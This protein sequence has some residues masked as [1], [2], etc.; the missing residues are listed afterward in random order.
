MMKKKQSIIA[1]VLAAIVTVLLGWTMI[2]GWGSTGTGSMKNINL[3]LDL[4][5]G[6]SITY[7]AVKD[8]PTDEEMSDTRY[9]LEQRAQQYSEEAQVY[10]QGDNRITIEIP[11]ATDATTILEEMGKPGSLYFIK[12]TNDDGTENYTYDSSTGEY[13]LN[14]KTI[15]ELEE[16]GSVV[17]TGKDVESA[18]AMHQQ[19]STTKATESVVQL[20]MTDEGK[21][22]FADATQEAY[23]AGKSIGIYY[24][25][26]FVS[27]PSVNAVISDGTAV[28]SGGN[29]DWDEATSLASTLRIGSLSL[30]LEE[31]NS[32]VVGAQLGSAAVSTS[33]KAGAIGIILI[34][35][36]LAVVYRLP[37]IAGVILSIGMAVDANVIIYARIEEEIGAGKTVHAA[38]RDGFKKATSA[39][40]DGNVTTLIAAAVLYALASGSVRGFA[41]TLALG[42]V[43][44][45]FSA[46]V[47]SRLLVNSLYGM[48]LKDAKYYGTKKERKGFP[49]MEKRKIFFTISCILLLAVPASM[50]FMHQTKGSALNFGLDFKGGTSINVPFNEDYSIEELDKEVEPV[51]E[52]VT[53][54]SNIQMT[55]V[56]GG[57]NVIIKTRSLTLEEREQV[58]QAM[59]D[60][61]GVDTSEITF[62]NISSTVSK[63]MSQNAMKA[64][65]IAVVCMLLYIWIRFRDIR[66]AS[67]AILAL[68][69]DIA[70]VFGFYVV[71]RISVGSTFIA[72]MLTILGYSINSTIVIF[73]RIRENLPELKREPIESLVDRC[74]TDTLTRSIYS[75]LTTFITIFVLFVMGVSSIRDFAAPLMVGIVC[76]AYTSV[77]ITGALWYVMKHVGKNKYVPSK[78]VQN[79]TKNK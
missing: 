6:V 52:G 28:I 13:V 61:F 40:L 75:S 8:N 2:K 12:Q 53:K 35:I 9:K 76:G 78:A 4:S 69:H 74:I 71:S 3:G 44:S 66:F 64:V 55:K 29:M 37:G 34:I 20:K 48:G 62:D 68:M 49:F 22:K 45:M 24:D 31:I 15:E 42:I 16:D 1:L 65:I 47:V 23:S 46:M 30:K 58:Y 38:I 79:K 33:V 26:K 60:N 19:N 39:I 63:E 73:D 51:V 18:E 5:G 67:S 41:M 72:C 57:N 27:V 7:Q 50:I 54:D 14:G 17:L 59:A 11:G 25:E 77:C 10:L 70:I 43:L 21:Q 36:F 56:V 32:S